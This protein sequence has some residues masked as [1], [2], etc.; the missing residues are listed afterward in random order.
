MVGGLVGACALI[1][2]L[3][4]DA[5]P[6]RGMRSDPDAVGLLRAAADAARRI[7]YEGRRFLTTW[8]RTRSA[9]SEV[10]VTHRPGEGA[11]YVS[12]AGAQG[13]RPDSAAGETAGFTIATLS[14]LTRNYSVVRAGD[15][16]VC[17]RRARVVEARRADGST[18]GRFWIDSET[19]LMLRR[20]LVDATGHRV[21]A[22][23]FTEI[24]L[25]VSPRRRS[26]PRAAP[27]ARGA[28]RTDP[29]MMSAPSAALTPWE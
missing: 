26:V 21:V 2:A 23:G 13:Y 5:G 29:D 1:G 15:T 12:A 17:G 9:T 7:P 16:S 4:G 28:D 22:A 27:P 25:V 6:A 10:G 18:A 14:L 3:T 20:E 19:G 11:R 24:D 8:S